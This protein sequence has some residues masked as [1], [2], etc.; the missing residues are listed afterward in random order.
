MATPDSARYLDP[1]HSDQGR[2]QRISRTERLLRSNGVDSEEAHLL[3]QAIQLA[4]QRE[5]AIGLDVS[6]LRTVRR[7]L[8]NLRGQAY[9]K[10]HKLVMEALTRVSDAEV[11]FGD[12]PDQVREAHSAFC[13]E[14]YKG[15]QTRFLDRNPDETPEEFVDRPRKSTLNI[16]QLVIHTLSKLYHKPPVRKLEEDTAAHVE[17]ALSEIWNDLHNLTWLEADRYTRLVGTVAIRPFYDATVPGRIR[18][19]VF[20]SHQ[21]RVVPDEERPWE[22]AAVIERVQPFARRHKATIW[23]AK[24]FVTLKNNQVHYEPHSMGRVPHVFVRDRL[25][26]TSFFVEGRG[27]ILCDPNA[28]LNNDLTDLEEVKQLQGFATLQIVNPAED[29]IR[30]GPREAF[31]FRPKEAGEPYGIQYVSPGAPI[32][33]LRQDCDRQISNILRVNRVPEAALGAEIGRRSLS[34]R[35]IQAAMQPLI[36]DLEE[37]GRLF[38]PLERDY[39]DAALRVKNEYEPGF[40]YDPL[41]QA[42]YFQ[43]DWAEMSFPLD[44][45]DQIAQDEFDVAHGIRTPAEI[46]RREDPDRYET[47]EA[48]V[49][50]WH[51]NLAEMNS[52][53]WS[54][55]REDEEQPDLQA[56][57]VGNEPSGVHQTP[58]LDMLE[59]EGLVNRLGNN[60]AG[61]GPAWGNGNGA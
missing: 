2:Q 61:D 36:E 5:P 8:A 41:M 24:S 43:T 51:K 1:H 18:P 42:P 17:A 6:P 34:G 50:Q 47:H 25:S 4:R 7:T 16:T 23:T 10:H 15:N 40:F 57:F 32:G 53:G 48:A 59:E 49:E 26:F 46:I 27:R 60:P 21:L 55:P 13:Y 56:S 35:A 28:I 14:M 9:R 52:A 44:T 33:E 29:D 22:P 20:L 58:I 39:A 45:A 54:P 31:V 37:R 3:A 30:V 38:E 11:A 19:W 12:V